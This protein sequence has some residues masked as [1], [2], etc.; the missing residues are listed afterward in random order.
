MTPTRIAL[1]DSPHEPVARR[2]VLEIDF[3]SEGQRDRWV[4]VHV[5]RRKWP[6][7]SAALDAAV[8]HAIA[9]GWLEGD[10]RRVRL[11]DRGRA[12]VGAPARRS[13]HL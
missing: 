12:L 5:L 10:A 1:D 4:L 11:L 7:D 13:R 9:R 2:L 3:A 6:F 8:S